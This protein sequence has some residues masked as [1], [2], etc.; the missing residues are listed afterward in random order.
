LGRFHHPAELALMLEEAG[1]QVGQPMGIAWNPLK[2]LH[3][4][5]DMALNYILTAVKKG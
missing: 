5:N 3:L 2:G 4:S 1:M